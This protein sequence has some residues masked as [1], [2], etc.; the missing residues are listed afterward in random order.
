MEKI[1]VLIVEDELLVAADLKSK[2]EDHGFIV[3]NTV[4]SGEEAL[5]LI[6]VSTPDLLLMDIQLAGHS[7]LKF[8]LMNLKWLPLPSPL[9][10]QPLMK[11]P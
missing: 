10:E 3:I 6:T 9:Q 4:A 8:F 7:A 1:K 2:L 5:D 11:R